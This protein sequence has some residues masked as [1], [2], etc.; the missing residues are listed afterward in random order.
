MSTIR[1]DEGLV[2][3]ANVFAERKEAEL[4]GAIQ[5]LTRLRRGID[6]RVCARS[7]A[8]DR[9]QGLI[10]DLERLYDKFV[11]IED[12]AGDACRKYV[13][14]D[15]YLVKV[16]LKYSSDVFDQL[17]SRLA[18]DPWH[19]IA[20]KGA[21]MDFL[22]ETLDPEIL[23]RYG[24]KLRFELVEENG[25]VYI[26]MINAFLP[27]SGSSHYNEYRDAL[28]RLSG[29][30]SSDFNRRFVNRLINGG[31]IPLYVKGRGIITDNMDLFKNLP[32]VDQYIRRIQMPWYGK[33]YDGLKTGFADSLKSTVTIWDD[34]NWKNT[35]LLAKGGK[36]MGAA[37]TV[38]TVGTNFVE[39]FH[40]G[41]EW[42]FSF[43]NVKKFTNNV[44]V[45]LAFGIG[46][47]AVGAAAGAAIGSFVMP[48]LG[49]IAGFAIGAGISF[50]ANYKFGGP[51]P[52][53]VVDHT[54]D[55]VNEVDEMVTDLTNQALDAG[56]KLV[57]NVGKKLSAVFW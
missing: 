50:A 5:A 54:K 29:G 8:D 11:R 41:G 33:M 57:G 31:G 51:P 40:D 49:T 18:L 16:G 23:L 15:D 30:D 38:F 1:I 45:D 43:S 25:K 14:I 24:D 28:I 7:R 4:K 46:S 22:S 52:K 6:Y 20:A 12:F 2:K 26:K 32:Q 53:S 35:S 39:T 9:L 13:D 55:L 48:P 17:E 19:A 10:N 34:F 44:G 36:F 21:A 27:A 3:T 37:G 42:D 47:A 56:S